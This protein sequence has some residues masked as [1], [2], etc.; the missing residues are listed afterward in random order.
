VPVHH[1]KSGSGN[2]P[3]LRG[4][5]KEVA[6]A[7][8]MSFKLLKQAAGFLGLDFKVTLHGS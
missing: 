4:A 2:I 8:V 1:P 5:P 7:V 3:G 6:L